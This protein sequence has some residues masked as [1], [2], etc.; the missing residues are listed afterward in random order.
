MRN[1][2]LVRQYQAIRSLFERTDRA[3]WQDIELQGHWGNY[4]CVLAAGLLENSVREVYG[5]FVRNASSPQVAN[6]AVAG[7][8]NVY[9]PKASRFIE[10]ARSF[11][12]SW[13]RDLEAYMN[14]GTGE[15]RDAI[16]SIMNNR[17]R[18]AHGRST[19]ISVAR[20]RDYLERAI[21]VIDFSESKCRGQR[22]A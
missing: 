13:G 16:D 12:Q 11:D 8:N 4:L 21:E 20:V 17:H 9:S 18:I 1:V 3:A 19:S 14:V 7:L 15:R 10:I 2:Q 5:E 22:T 6:H